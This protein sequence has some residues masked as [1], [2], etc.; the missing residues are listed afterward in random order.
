MRPEE[1]DQLLGEVAKA[2]HAETF[3]KEFVKPFVEQKRAVLLEAFN[4]IDPSDTKSLS[5]IRRMFIVVDQFYSEINEFV[6]TGRMAAIQLSTG[7]DN[8]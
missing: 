4:R 5:E 2:R 7:D 1:K 6:T 3:I 8:D